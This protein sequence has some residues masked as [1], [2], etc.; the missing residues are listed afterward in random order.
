MKTAAAAMPPHFSLSPDASRAF[1][2]TIAFMVPLLLATR[3]WLPVEVS[4]MALAA[5][6]IAMLDVRGDYRLRVALVLAMT[7]VFT[8]VA[9]LGALAS[10]T[11][12]TALLATIAV[13][14]LGS[15]WRHLSSDYG[16]SLA[17]SSTLVFLIA[18]ASPGGPSAAPAN[19]LAA[20]VGGAWGVMVQL[21]SWPFRAQHPLRRTVSDSWLAVA[22]LF[23]VLSPTDANTPAQR[24]AK[25]IEA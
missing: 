14:I 16:P 24:H 25:V 20:I 23:D 8:G 1:R 22:A 4:F 2:A 12:V 18:L 10:A 6:N 15:L 3:G 5:Q 21:A 9:A 13:A 7:L 19:A 17:I 11:V